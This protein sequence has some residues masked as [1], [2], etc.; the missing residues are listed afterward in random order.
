VKPKLDTHVRNASS[1]LTESSDLPHMDPEY[2]RYKR[3]YPHFPGIAACRDMLHRNNIQGAYLDAIIADL[4]HHV[5]DQ[6]DELIQAIEQEQDARVRR[7]LFAALVHQPS[8][9]AITLCRHFLTGPD[10][11]LRTYAAQGLARLNTKQARQIL[12]QARSHQ[13]AD[14]TETERFRKLLNDLK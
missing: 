11:H 13:F 8:D 9:D 3:N 5:A 12:W 7:I 4:E 14:Y 6:Y 10:E 2:Q 1:D